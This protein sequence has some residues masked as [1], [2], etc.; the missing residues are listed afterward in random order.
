[1]SSIEA[2]ANILLP[3]ANNNYILA[4]RSKILILTSN[5]L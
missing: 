2:Q 3:L 1:M 4:G 5:F